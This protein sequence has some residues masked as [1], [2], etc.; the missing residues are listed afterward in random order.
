[1]FSQQ[2]FNQPNPYGRIVNVTLEKRVNDEINN[3]KG[4]IRDGTLKGRSC[5][6][7][8]GGSKEE[9]GQEDVVI[10]ISSRPNA[11]RLPNNCGD[12]FGNF[13]TS[14]LLTDPIELRSNN[15]LLY[16]K[17]LE[18]MRNGSQIPSYDDVLRHFNPGNFRIALYITNTQEYTY[19]VTYSLSK[20]HVMLEEHT[21]RIPQPRAP[22]TVIKRYL[23]RK[24]QN[25]EVRIVLLDENVTWTSFQRAVEHTGLYLLAMEALSSPSSNSYDHHGNSSALHSS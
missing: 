16:G 3:Y 24:V 20:N 8:Y 2:L 22:H 14:H 23:A 9:L 12:L 4:V 10:R 25:E 1:M 7:L 17:F 15:T 21:D 6:V 18:Y 5:Y 13:I 11:S 19:P